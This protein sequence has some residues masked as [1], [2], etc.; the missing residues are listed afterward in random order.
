[1]P[2]KKIAV[3]GYGTAGAYALT[4]FYKWAPDCELELHFDSQI[5][6]QP[7]GEGSTV[8]FPIALWQNIHFSYSDLEKIDGT[9]K[10]GIKKT[11]W[12]D[13]KEYIHEFGVPTVSYHFNAGIL[14]K[15]LV[16]R[17]KDRVKVFDHNVTHDSIDADY[18]LD[19]SGKPKSYEDF[20]VADAIAVNS[21]HVTQCY[22][23]YPRFQY[24]L[25]LA[26]PYGWVFGIPLRNRCAIGYLYNNNFNT[27]E[28]V[29]E[30]VKNVFK[31]YN[32]EPSQDTNT[33][34]FHNYYRKENYS[35]R[36]CYSGNASFFLEPMEAT[37]IATMD[38]IQR[39]AYDVWFNNY[40]IDKQN[41]NYIEFIKE[42]QNMI[43]LHYYSGSMFDTEFW[44]A[45]QEK[46]R[47]NIKEA[48]KNPNFIKA[49]NESKR[50]LDDLN[51]FPYG[52]W[53]TYSMKQ[54]LTNLNLYEK[55]E[56][57]NE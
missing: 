33:F 20:H 45:S 36:V 41:A 40:S 50:D 34:S 44:K 6:P 19:C 9:F 37:S 11:G 16:E 53:N 10:C 15:Y 54:N 42:V 8:H 57:E 30:D 17:L 29:K 14:Q 38:T 22:W 25:T 23:D 27:L 55:L 2:K 18:I 28:E 1:M 4:H 5:K 35:K 7:V 13:G 32:L 39:Q 26:R 21:V 31:E 47:N 24:T 43:S 49:I 52:T 46:G 12:A 3:V 51:D 48:L 56:K